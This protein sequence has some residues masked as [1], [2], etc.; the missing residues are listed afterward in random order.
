MS[1]YASARLILDVVPV[2]ARG[3]EAHA[4]VADPD[5]LVGRGVG[6]GRVDLE[7]HEPPR[8]SL[9]A[10]PA[11]G[12]GAD[13]VALVEGDEPVETAHRRRDVL[14]ELGRPDAVALL[15]AQAVDRAVADGAKAAGLA[16]FPELVP[17][18]AVPVRRHDDLV[19]ELAG[20]RDAPDDRPGR[21]DVDRSRRPGTRTPR[22]ETSSW[23]ELARGSRATPARTP[24]TPCGRRTGSAASRRSAAGARGTSAGASPAG[25]RSR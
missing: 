23:C 10:R 4:S 18:R 7:Q 9:V 14:A 24:R 1:T 5:A 13:E 11:R 21:A 6:V 15:E 3:H 2:G 19:A 22:S 8:R 16:G 25:S 12:L 17:E 20:Q